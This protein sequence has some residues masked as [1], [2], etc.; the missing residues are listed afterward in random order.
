M[1][2]DLIAVPA[3]AVSGVSCGGALLVHQQQTSK[4]SLELQWDHSDLRRKGKPHYTLQTH[5]V[6]DICGY[7]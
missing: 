1:D 4:Q 5:T 6:P 2:T 7:T 3:K